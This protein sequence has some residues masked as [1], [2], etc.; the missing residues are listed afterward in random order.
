MLP[1]LAVA[2][3][4]H[5]VSTTSVVEECHRAHST[6]QI[7]AARASDHHLFAADFLLE[8]VLVVDSVGRGQ[9][10]EPPGLL[11]VLGDA[12]TE[13]MTNSNIC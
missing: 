4:L 5:Q 12:I 7:L 3:Q 13:L 10:I 1:S 11:V 2:V 8:S 9:C 6:I